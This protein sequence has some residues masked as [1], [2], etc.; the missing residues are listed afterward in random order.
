MISSKTRLDPKQDFYETVSCKTA[1]IRLIWTDPELIFDFL[2]QDFA[3][4]HDRAGS[5][6]SGEHE[7]FAWKRIRN[8][9]ENKGTSR[10]SCKRPCLKLD[11][12]R[13]KQT[14]GWPAEALETRVKDWPILLNHETNTH[15]VLFSRYELKHTG[16]SQEKGKATEIYNVRTAV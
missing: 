1:M 8:T 14:L 2:N 16:Q 4:M 10:F 15:D 5:A 11:G 3:I 12:R 7:K 9:A 6:P 13:K